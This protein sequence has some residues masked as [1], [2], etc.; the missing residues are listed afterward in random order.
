MRKASSHAVGESWRP[1]PLQKSFLVIV[2]IV[3][4]LSP[5][6]AQEN[7]ANVLT[8]VQS[9]YEAGRT[10]EMIVRLNRCLPDGIPGVAEKVRAYKFLALAYIAED[11]PDG[12]KEAVEKL[13]LLNANFAPDRATDPSKFIAL[14]EEAQ[15]IRSRKK[16]RKKRIFYIGGTLLAGIAT[17]AIL[18]TGSG[19]GPPA[20]RL[21][22]PPVFPER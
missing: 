12:A 16:S 15:K 13:L 21:P 4:W 11:L 20:V 19:G 14:V 10:A 22:D 17:A 2:C 7:C 18:F 6:A 5:S 3:G 1:M 9:L 8:E